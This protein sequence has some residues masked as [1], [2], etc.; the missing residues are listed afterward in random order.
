MTTLLDV[1]EHVTEIKLNE[2]I[3]QFT[4]LVLNPLTWEKLGRPSVIEVELGSGVICAV[5]GSLAPHQARAEH[6]SS[7]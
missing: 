7:N 3:P 6:R 2:E 1:R 5:D 4:H